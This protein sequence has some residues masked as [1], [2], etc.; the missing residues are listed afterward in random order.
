[1]EFLK[2]IL[3]EF[4]FED[5]A[6]PPTLSFENDFAD[7]TDLTHVVFAQSAMLPRE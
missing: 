5:L 7:L 3:Q 2:V 4:L 1:M 6:L